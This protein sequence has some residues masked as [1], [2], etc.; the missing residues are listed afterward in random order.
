MGRI[1]RIKMSRNS[2]GLKLDAQRHFESGDYHKALESL[3]QLSVKSLDSESRL[4]RARV[5]FKLG[6]IERAREEYE[7]L[8]SADPNQEELIRD[9]VELHEFQAN[10][11][12]VLHYL[13]LLFLQKTDHTREILQVLNLYRKLGLFDRALELFDTLDTKGF[14]SEVF[15]EEKAQ[16]LLD[17]GARKELQTLLKDHPDYFGFHVEL[18]KRIKRELKLT[19]LANGGLEPR[20][21][22][23]R[24]YGKILLGSY[25][26]DGDRIPVSSVQYFD[27]DHFYETCLRFIDFQQRNQ[28]QYVSVHPANPED[29]LLARFMAKLTGSVY[30]KTAPKGGENKAR[31]VVH[32]CFD[33]QEKLKADRDIY[34]LGFVLKI[35]DEE[36]PELPEFAGSLIVESGETRFYFDTWEG[37][38]SELVSRLYDSMQH[39]THISSLSHSGREVLGDFCEFTALRSNITRLPDRQF[40]GLEPS[41]QLKQLFSQIKTSFAQDGFLYLESFLERLSLFTLEKH[42]I[43]WLLSQH[44]E[45]GFPPCRLPE[46]CA[47]A[48]LQDSY[49][50]YFKSSG[51]NEIKS[52]LFEVI[53]QVPHKKTIGILM[54][55][56]K[57]LGPNRDDFISSLV[58]VYLRAEPE[59]IEVFTKDYLPEINLTCLFEGLESFKS[60]PDPWNSFLK[61][62]ILTENQEGRRQ[63]LCFFRQREIEFTDAELDAWIASSNEPEIELLRLM[64][65]R[66]RSF[67]EELLPWLK[68]QRQEGFYPEL[69]EGFVLKEFLEGE[70]QE[71]EKDLQS[72]LLPW[73]WF[74]EGLISSLLPSMERVLEL[75]GRPLKEEVFCLF[76]K[77]SYRVDLA[78]E[79]IFSCPTFKESMKRVVIT[80]L[81]RNK[82]EFSGQELLF[83]MDTEEHLRVQVA[84]FFL[85]CGDMEFFAFLMRRFKTHTALLGPTVI[86]LLFHCRP[87]PALR[88]FI[89][90]AA[91]GNGFSVAQ[92]LDVFDWLDTDDLIRDEW[93][94]LLKSPEMVD[95][96]RPF[97]AW[98]ELNLRNEPQLLKWYL[99][100]FPQEK[101]R[102]VVEEYFEVTYRAR[103]KLLA[104]HELDPDYTQ[105]LMDTLEPSHREVYL[106]RKEE[107]WE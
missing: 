41:T 80:F 69:I 43:Q 55:I 63:I 101:L 104:L 56:L 31:L 39:K 60:L 6:A 77:F 46:L 59:F 17:L 96:V 30:V 29:A 42:Q 44:K 79:S 3:E 95:S 92:C 78:L 38:A 8:L 82:R 61:T 83:L 28:I 75:M 19:P 33:P 26:D 47:R 103:E 58:W 76:L 71:Q 73:S 35:S 67:P 74:E 23:F 36:E 88:A 86:K 4:L 7:S 14:F 51:A 99:C 65:Q 98:F 50:F 87:D 68:T 93:M 85:G 22:Y 1:K 2:S 64:M 21:L 52:E 72:K 81:E 66:K 70:W 20:S 5:C 25:S 94:V 10:Y 18:Y 100:F 27:P 105:I 13:D 32:R 24:L 9:L 16:L 49:E 89:H 48:A 34:H 57:K 107:T 54:E 62:R 84:A 11:R 53:H 45:K 37:K 91:L 102:P 106:M 15:L 97:K 12:Q 40:A 90:Y